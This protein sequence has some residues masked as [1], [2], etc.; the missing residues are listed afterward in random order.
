MAL[1]QDSLAKDCLGSAYCPK[2]QSAVC[3]TWR[4]SAA[5]CDVNVSRGGGAHSMRSEG[6]GSR[7]PSTVHRTKFT[8]GASTWRLERQ[9]ASESL[10]MRKTTTMTRLSRVLV[11][12]VYPCHKHRLHGCCFEEGMK[13]LSSHLAESRDRA[14]K[15]SVASQSIATIK[16]AEPRL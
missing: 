2:I 7:Q 11:Q 8:S 1:G 15:S 10:S 16:L 12:V 4:A 9:T 6:H 5:M 3:S 14:V 13:S